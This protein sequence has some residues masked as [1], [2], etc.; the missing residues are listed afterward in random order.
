MSCCWFSVSWQ[1]Q[2][3][4]LSI[5][6][7]YELHTFSLQSTGYTK[8]LYLK[9]GCQN[10]ETKWSSQCRVS[11]NRMCYGW[12]EQVF[13]ENSVH[14]TVPPTCDLNLGLEKAGGKIIEV[15]SFFFFFFLR[16]GSHCVNLSDLE[17]RLWTRQLWTHSDQLSLSLLP[18]YWN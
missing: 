2:P 13:K 5:E 11:V 17:I 16:T 9:K 8:L 15:F 18:V 7:R 12:G 4:K 14:I 6:T 3:L 10:R 1:L